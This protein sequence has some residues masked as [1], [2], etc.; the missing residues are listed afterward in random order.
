MTSVKAIKSSSKRER[1]TSFS[2]FKLKRAQLSKVNE[3]R[4]FECIRTQNHKDFQSLVCGFSK[5]RKVDSEALKF[6]IM[7]LKIAISDL[8]L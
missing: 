2:H 4:R 6:F 1:T 8:Y 7:N 3:E 5:L